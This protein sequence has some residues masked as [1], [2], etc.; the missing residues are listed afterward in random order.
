MAF[1]GVTKLS[2]KNGMNIK[3]KIL[4]AKKRIKELERLIAYWEN[5][6]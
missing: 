3:E 6:K 4:Q 5:A 1:F 2:L